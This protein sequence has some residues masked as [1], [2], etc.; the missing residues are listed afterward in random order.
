MLLLPFTDSTTGIIVVFDIKFS[1]ARTTNKHIII[2][3]P[4]VFMVFVRTVQVWGDLITMFT[5]FWLRFSSAYPEMNRRY[6][7][8]FAD[9]FRYTTACLGTI[10]CHS[11]FCTVRNRVKLFLTNKTWFS[12]SYLALVVTGWRTKFVY[13][14]SRIKFFIA[15]LARFQ[16]VT[17]VPHV[18]KRITPE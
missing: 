10:F 11:Y 9:N 2:Q 4:A 18:L 1:M 7:R 15:G 6:P 14:Q 3:F 13:T 5:L 12:V 17:I 8:L 16:H